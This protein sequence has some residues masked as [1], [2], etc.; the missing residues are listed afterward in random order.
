LIDLG[1]GDAKLD[2]WTVW[3]AIFL[4]GAT[5]LAT[6]GAFILFFPKVVLPE[7]LR[8]ALRFV[9]PAVFAALVV[10][11]LLFAGA[12][13]HLALTN[14]KLLAGIAAAAIAALSRNALATIIGGMAA[15]HVLRF[16][17]VY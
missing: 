7:V 6:R 9:P 12:N 3:P 15:L 8:R 2:A 13:L 14:E 5:T 4:L 1:A 10:P 17:A 16:I 11:E